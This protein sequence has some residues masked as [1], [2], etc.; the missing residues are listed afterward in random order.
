MAIWVLFCLFVFCCRAS[1]QLGCFSIL[2]LISSHMDQMPDG[3]YWDCHRQRNS[4]SLLIPKW[5]STVRWKAIILSAHLNP[6]FFSTRKGVQ[7]S[8]HGGRT[9]FFFIA[10][11]LETEGRACQAKG[12]LQT[13]T[14]S[15][16]SIYSYLPSGKLT[17]RY[18]KSP[19]GKVRQINYF[20]GPC[21]TS[22]TVPSA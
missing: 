21:S 11:C 8:K 12:Q 16:F 22:Q 20:R 13:R 1:S 3:I 5:Q 10:L 14:V 17:V 4:W 19:S 9:L 2:W 18:G 15:L 6:F 7:T